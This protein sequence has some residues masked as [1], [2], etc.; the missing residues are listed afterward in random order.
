MA[1]QNQTKTR[2]QTEPMAGPEPSGNLPDV[3]RVKMSNFMQEFRARQRAYAPLLPPHLPFE[4]FEASVRAAVTKNPELVTECIPATLFRAAAEAAELGLSLS[5]TLREADILKV[6]NKRLGPKGGYEAQFRPRFIGYQK[7][8]K[9]SGEIVDIDAHEVY[10]WDEFDYQYG[11]NEYL[12]HRPG[13][14]PM[15]YQTKPFWGVRFAYC[16]WELAGGRKK[17]EVMDLPDIIRI[18]NRTQSKKKKDYNDPNSEMEITGPWVTDF[19][20]MARKTVVRRAS[21]YMPLSAEKMRGFA[22]AVNLDDKREGGEDVTLKGGEVVDV[23]EFSETQHEPEQQQQPKQTA[24]GKSQL[25]DLES[26]MAGESG[27]QQPRGAQ[28]PPQHGQPSAQPGQPAAKAAGPV[29][30]DNPP[31]QKQPA[32]VSRLEVPRINGATD[33]TTWLKLSAVAVQP[34]NAEQRAA[35]KAQHKD[36]LDNCEFNVPEKMDELLKMLP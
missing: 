10:E 34:L 26:K 29:T 13:L 18:M 30:I 21:K 1:K 4:K 12:K 27:K 36:L 11:L 31:Q 16:T 33:W 14:K 32:Q 9:N 8:A 19:P 5:P 25:D 22:A 28:N 20:E 6:Y 23:T 2:Q 17:F 15:D 7:L 35:W 3:I 24:T